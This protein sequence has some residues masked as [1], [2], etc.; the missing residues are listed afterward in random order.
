MRVKNQ[1]TQKILL[2]NPKQVQLRVK[3]GTET[4]RQGVV[5]Q[6]GM[7]CVFKEQMF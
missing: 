2:C 7:H 3:Q 4:C 1:A 6:E 5:E